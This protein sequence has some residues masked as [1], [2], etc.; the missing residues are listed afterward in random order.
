MSIELSC[1]HSWQFD[2]GS[3]ELELDFAKRWGDIILYFQKTTPNCVLFLNFR[4]SVRQ[5]GQTC[6]GGALVQ[7]SSRGQTWSYTCSSYHGKT[8]PQNGKLIF[9]WKVMAYN[10]VVNDMTRNCELTFFLKSNGLQQCGEWHGQTLG[11]PQNCPQE[12]LND[13]QKFLFCVAVFW[14]KSL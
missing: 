12:S 14:E 10:N 2:I 8:L 4:G 3:V 6:W 5:H 9:V 11:L 13:P 1:T 7:K